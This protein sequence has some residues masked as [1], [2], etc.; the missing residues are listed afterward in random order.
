MPNKSQSASPRELRISRATEL[1]KKHPGWGKDRVNAELK[2]EFGSGLQRIAMAR[3]KRETLSPTLTKEEKRA[4]T[5]VKR[6]LLPSEAREIAKFPIT[7]LAVKEYVRERQKLIQTARHDK[8]PLASLNKQIKADWKIEGYTK[9]GKTDFQKVFED[10]AKKLAK[11][12]NKKYEVIVEAPKRV[13]FT[14]EEYKIYKELR[15]H[16]FTK[17]EAEKLAKGS[18]SVNAFHS[19]PWRDAMNERVAWVKD[20]LAKGWKWSRILEE[21]KNYYRHGL[22]RSPFDFIRSSYNPLKAHK[23]PIEQDE[24]TKALK[25]QRQAKTKAGRLAGRRLQHHFGRF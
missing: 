25:R 11:Y 3:L 7:S 14:E 18:T 12:E 4:V 10:Y 13:T 21:I 23:P 5:L 19:Q 20:K 2:S 6:G 22:K 16:Y 9:R 15:A 17:D 24:L 8:V 1:I